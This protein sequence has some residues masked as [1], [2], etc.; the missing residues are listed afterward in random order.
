M[1]KKYLLKYLFVLF[2]LPFEVFAQSSIDSLHAELALDQTR[3]EAVVVERLRLEQQLERHSTIVDSL[4]RK[5]DGNK[6]GGILEKTLQQSLAV[7][8]AIEDCYRQ[9]EEVRGRVFKS[10]E[11]LQDRYDLEIG[12]LVQDVSLPTNPEKMALL[13]YLQKNRKSL[14][15]LH[16]AEYITRPIP[17]LGVRSD[18]D[19][20]AI[21]QKAEL[22]ADVAKEVKKDVGLIEHRLKK[23]QEEQRLRGRVQTFSKE[24]FLFDESVIEGRS[25]AVGRSDGKAESDK[26]LETTGGTGSLVGTD[27]GSRLPPS[28]SLVPVSETGEVVLGREVGHA[29]SR[30]ETV[31][32]EGDILLLEIRRLEENRSVLMAREKQVD[33]RV[34]LLHQYLESLLGDTR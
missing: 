7:A 30:A 19:P 17:Q 23:L 13:Q 27:D 2:A 9:E 21:R 26:G 8:L 31:L 15:Q 14:F 10:K 6:A 20:E 5:Q 4:K 33:A 34:R 18:D 22:M 3:L 11:T 28:S 24:L 32:G 29:V 1:M 16:A 12:L 25:V